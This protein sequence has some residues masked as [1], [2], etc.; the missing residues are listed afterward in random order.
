MTLLHR[1]ALGAFLLLVPGWAARAEDG[2][3]LA[4]PPDRMIALGAAAEEECAA[5]LRA[6]CL[7]TMALGRI[8]AA[9]QAGAGRA[10]RPARGSAQVIDALSAGG[11]EVTLRQ[12]LA[13]ADAVRRTPPGGS[14]AAEVWP[15]ETRLRAGQVAELRL[16][17]ERFPDPE[18]RAEQLQTLS[19]RTLDP[20]VITAAAI[21]APEHPRES[22]RRILIGWTTALALASAQDRRGLA[23]WLEDLAAG[24]PFTEDANGVPETRGTVIVGGSGDTIIG[25][26]GSTYAGMRNLPRLSAYAWMVAGD[27]PAALAA[28]DRIRW[29]NARISMLETIA[30]YSARLRGAAWLRIVTIGLEHPDDA[31]IRVPVLRAMIRLGRL[32]EAEAGIKALGTRAADDDAMLPRLLAAAQGRSGEPEGARRIADWLGDVLGAE[33]EAESRSARHREAQLRRAAELALRVRLAGTVAD[34][35]R[36]REARAIL[37]EHAAPAAVQDC[38]ARGGA[39]LP[40]ALLLQAIE[41]IA[42]DGRS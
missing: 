24:P 8:V 14:D 39:C 23:E 30:R 38:L 3:R 13:L 22:E 12:V 18:R 34:P 1:M 2:A 28:A 40:I 11:H 7:A 6:R 9:Q 37:A 35:G 5:A 19:M 4:L 29:R 42:P 41:D 36:Q 16:L 17:F 20:L 25:A 21:A 10:I 32:E 15:P 27:G 31:G 26:G 33:A